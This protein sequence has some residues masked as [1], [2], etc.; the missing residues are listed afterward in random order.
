MTVPPPPNQWGSQ[1]P[2]G[3]QPA[4]APQ[5]GPPPGGAPQWGPQQPWG[6]PPGPPPSGGG[7][8]KW[9]FGGIALLAV[10]AVTVVITVLV[11]GKNSGGGESP[12]PTTG[13]ASDFASA[14]D[15]GP[16]GIIT[17]DPTCESWRRINNSV[18]AAQK[19]VSWPERD[20]S[21]PATAWD[22][23]QR[24][25]Y[26]AVDKSIG[27]AA[28]Q[29]VGIVKQTPHRVMREFYEQFIAYAR[30]FSDI[31]PS[32]TASE[33]DRNLAAAPDNVALTITGICSAI[34]TGSAGPIA[35]LVADVAAPAEIS[36]PG[37]PADPQRFLAAAS[38]VCTEWASALARFSDDTVAWRAIDANI[39]ATDWT[40]DQKGVNDAV[41]PKM[42]ALADQLEE[43]GRESHNPTLEDFALLSAQYWRAFG[44]ALP[45]YTSADI[46]LGN[47]GNYAM[48]VVEEA[49]G[50][51]R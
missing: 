22:P 11:V 17:D 15:K 1:P 4:G 42:T 44:L 29:V 28:D 21:V 33:R 37:D 16:V 47:A 14:N 20:Q 6:P 27:A 19:G 45:T 8:G 30:A 12:A 32:Y 18:A 10:I 34:V 49:C 2:T 23:R 41:M 48:Y 7:K 9:I 5:W 51:A 50:A 3:G 43:L 39:P 40:P 38:P 26:E 36:A 24:S 31:V 46:Y 25:M 35:P 13:N